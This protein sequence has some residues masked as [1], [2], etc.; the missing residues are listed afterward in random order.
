MRVDASREIGIG[1]FMRS[2]ALADA[3]RVGGAQTRFVAATFSIAEQF[4]LL[5]VV[6][7][8]HYPAF[9]DYR[10]KRYIIKMEKADSGE[11]N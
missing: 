1:H 8:E 5:R 7:P 4:D 6:D 9:F 2:L 11:R 3:L 10:G